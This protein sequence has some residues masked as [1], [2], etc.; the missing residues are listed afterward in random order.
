MAKT[1]WFHMQG[2]RDLPKDFKQR[3]ESSWVSPPNRELCDSEK[4]REYVNLN[5][6]ELEFADDMGFDGV[7][8]NEHHANVYGFPIAPT[9]TAATLAR[10]QSDAAIC[11]L[12]TTIPTTVTMRVAEEIA[13]LDCMSGG[14]IIAGQPVGSAMDTVG[15]GGIPP[16]QVRKRWY[17]GMELIRQAWTKPGPF[18]FNGKFNKL[19]NV[20]P[21]PLP[22]QDPHPPLWLAGGGSLETYDYA[23]KYNYAYS[24]LSFNG[25]KY[26]KSLMQ[27]YWDVIEKA[28]L[29]DNPYRAGFAQFILVA[30]TD[31]EAERLYA[32]H[33]ENFYNKSM[34]IPPH[35][36]A[37]PGYMSKQSLENMMLKTGTASPFLTKQDPTFKDAVASGAAICGSPDTVAE[38]LIDAIK[39]LRVGHLI[40]L[41]QM[42]S[43]PTEL[44]KMNTQ[45]FAEKVMPRIRD[46]WK[47]EGYVDHWWPSG[48]TRNADV[49]QTVAA[50]EAK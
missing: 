32:E 42:Q 23:A 7:G 11:I 36:S 17:E 8:T 22:L 6:D 19:R 21:W 48:A 30:D 4:V 31:A 24:Y 44:T 46:I 49:A 14:R 33:V 37:P 43:M 10:R 26:A 5:L 18:P 28:G 16:T 41:M 15:V 25:A 47:E 45:L 39:D 20:N 35:F 29:D 34:H 2:Y 12:G 9:L 50:G 40:A 13:W 38:Q 27:G 1:I 3:Y